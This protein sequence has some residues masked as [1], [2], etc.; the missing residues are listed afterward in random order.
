MEGLLMKG[1]LMKGSLMVGLLTMEGRWAA[2]NPRWLARRHSGNISICHDPY[3]SH[4][5]ILP[6]SNMTGSLLITACVLKQ[7]QAPQT[8]S[9]HLTARTHSRPSRPRSYIRATARPKSYSTRPCTTIPRPHHI[10]LAS[11]TG[12]AGTINTWGAGQGHARQY[13]N[14]KERHAWQ[15][16]EHRQPIALP[17]RIV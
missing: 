17:L 3:P 15:K 6:F 13:S 11:A 9:R 16:T 2:T 8:L 5:G 1:S 7:R 4:L 12:P 10:S 14:Y